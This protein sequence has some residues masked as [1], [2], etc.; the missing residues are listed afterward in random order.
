ME[1]R[2][3]TAVVTL[4]DC[5]SFHKAAERLGVD[6]STLSRRIQRLE[7]E[8]GVSV[9]ARSRT[10][11]VPTSG[12]RELL[13]LARRIVEDVADLKTGADR[14]GRAQ[15]GRLRL[16]TQLSVLGS[17]IRLALRSFR[18]NHPRVDLELTEADDKEIISGLHDYRY[19]AAIL[20][21]PTVT[22]RVA[23]YELWLERLVLGVA[24]QH[25]LAGQPAVT[26][27]DIRREPLIV[28]GWSSSEAYRQLETSLVGPGADF[29]SHRAGCGELM[30]LVAI[31]E[32]V[33]IVLASHR[34]FRAPGVRLVDINEP[35]ATIG[36][37]LAWSPALEEPIAGSFVAF[38]RDLRR[39]G[40]DAT[41]RTHDPPP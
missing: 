20:F 35:N 25:P 19:D 17:D 23:S 27:E 36:I 26:W 30:G 12:G 41:W 2:D 28:Q 13:R 40:P 21:T 29:R 38:M 22:E 37:S 32:G 34:E 16:A 15:I 8:L 33:M 14:A 6:T 5:G 24:D 3:L 1:L 18:E 10:G 7:D 4:A 9:F 11:I 31:G 39:F